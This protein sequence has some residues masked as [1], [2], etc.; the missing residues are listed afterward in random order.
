M[1]QISAIAP[2]INSAA[3]T[4]AKIAG[5]VV[6]T[7]T[8]PSPT[9][10]ES[11]TATA[12]RPAPSSVTIS[13]ELIGTNHATALGVVARSPSP[14]LALCRTLVEAGHDPATPLHA[15]R[16]NTLALKVRSI[17]EG[18]KLTVEDNH[19]GKPVFRPQRNRPQNDGAGP[20]IALAT[21]GMGSMPS[22]R[23]DEAWRQ[24]GTVARTVANAIRRRRQRKGARDEN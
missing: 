13:A 12:V 9:S 5:L 2:T 21:L 4:T 15:Y 16:G 22:T 1:D 3:H 24:I 14:V 10:C 11:V 23:R 17:G 7:V 20:P 6:N 19:L 18:A 8:P